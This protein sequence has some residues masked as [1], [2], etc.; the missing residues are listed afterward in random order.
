MN[1]NFIYPGTF[2]PITNGHVD[3]IKRA[4]NI[5]DSLIIAVAEDGSKSPLFSPS[6]RCDMIKEDL[7]SRG[8][9]EMG[10]LKICSFSGLLIDFA[11]KNDISVIVRGLRAVSD[12]EYEFQLAAMNSRLMPDIQTVFLPAS[13]TRQF[14]ASRLVKEIAGLG[15][16]VSPFVSEVVAKRLREVYHT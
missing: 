15:G 16:D 5:A 7:R 1:R 6:E 4:L 14:V 12:F 10:R 11:R 3:I 9:G 13:E 2:D 8:C